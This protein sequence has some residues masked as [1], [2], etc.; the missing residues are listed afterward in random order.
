MMKTFFILIFELEFQMYDSPLGKAFAK[1]DIFSHICPKAALYSGRTERARRNSSKKTAMADN[2]SGSVISSILVRYG[3]ATLGLV[4]V[5][6][7]VAL[8][9]KS[10]LGTS[11]VSCPPY[12]VNLWNS[13]LTVG[14]YTM[15][16]HMIF[17]LAQVLMLGKKFK[18]RYLMQIPAAIVFGLITDLAIWA[19]DW[20]QVSTY[21]GRM[22]LCVL[23]VIVT[24]LGVSLEVLGG[25]WMLAGEQTTAAISEVTGLAFNRA[26]IAFDVFLV[27]ISAAFA[28]IV[29]KN[30]L[31]HDHLYVIREGTLILAIFTGLCMRLT[32]PLAKAMFGKAIDKVTKN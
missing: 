26:K 15:I 20:I 19:F 21:A 7:G 23:T 9:I 25:A 8:S 31:G 29:F 30:P 4:L 10:D 13:K 2:K 6:I 14:E 16:M 22:F 5:G 12:V 17:I 18:L 3:V 32:D 1:V 28:W 11:P 27:I 24:A